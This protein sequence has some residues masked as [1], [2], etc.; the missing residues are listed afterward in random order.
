MSRDSRLVRP[1]RSIFVSAAVADCLSDTRTRVLSRGEGFERVRFV[2]SSLLI[3]SFSTFPL[4]PRRP[5]GPTIYFVL[6]LS[7]ASSV[8]PR[9]LR[10]FCC[11]IEMTDP[12]GTV[13]TACALLIL[14]RSAEG[15]V[16]LESVVGFNGLTG[17]GVQI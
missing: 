16:V 8:A 4:M 10:P 6:V 9:I 11:S 13:R 15:S 17:V 12:A 3:V 14:L 5:L 2:I 1:E 7:V